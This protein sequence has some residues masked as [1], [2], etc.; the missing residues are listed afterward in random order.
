M[1]EMAAGQRSCPDGRM[2]FVLNEVGMAEIH[3][4][5]YFRRGI[6]GRGGCVVNELRGNRFCD[7]SNSF[8]WHAAMFSRCDTGWFCQC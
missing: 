5:K 4:P 1:L 8:P 2:R 3:G 7:L 6:A